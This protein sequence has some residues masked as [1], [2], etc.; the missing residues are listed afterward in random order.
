MLFV[1][2]LVMVKKWKIKYVK[3]SNS[4]QPK[5]YMHTVGNTIGICDLVFDDIQ[6]RFRH[7]LSDTKDTF[8]EFTIT[9]SSSIRNFNL[10]IEKDNTIITF[11][12]FVIALVILFMIYAIYKQF[13]RSNNEENG[14]LI[15]KISGV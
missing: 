5:E 14:F 2:L 9:K 11:F 1:V 3:Y 4:D 7:I 10:F 6:M 15:A 8:D 13:K 12:F